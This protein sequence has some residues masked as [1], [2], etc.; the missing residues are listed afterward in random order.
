MCIDKEIEKEEWKEKDTMVQ[1]K[2]ESGQ[3]S[4]CCKTLETVL[5]KVTIILCIICCADENYLFSS[6]KVIA[7]RRKRRQVS[8]M[9][10]AQ[11]Y[12]HKAESRRI[13]VILAPACGNI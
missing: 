3:V 9:L 12:L 10:R 2:A 8:K 13:R 6:N 1:I 4:C 7:V 11:R 5:R